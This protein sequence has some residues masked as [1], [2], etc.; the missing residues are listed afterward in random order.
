M[1]K[2]NFALQAQKLSTTETP[3][4][5]TFLIIFLNVKNK[6]QQEPTDRNSETNLH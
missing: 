3:T 2:A 6:Q 5:I 1:S 4:N